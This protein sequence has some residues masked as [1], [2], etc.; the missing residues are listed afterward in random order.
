M[1][2]CE[3]EV[4]GGKT[5]HV[6]LTIDKGLN[7]ESARQL[8]NDASAKVGQQGRAE[9]EGEEDGESGEVEE[10]E[11][12]KEGR[13]KKRKQGQAEGGS[14]GKEKNDEG[15]PEKEG[16]DAK[17]GKEGKKETREA[18]EMRQWR[19]RAARVNGFYVSQREWLGRKHYVLAILCAPSPAQKASVQIFRPRTSAANRPTP[20]VDFL[21]KY[22]KL[23]PSKLSS[24]Q[25][26][27][28]TEYE[29]SATK[30]SRI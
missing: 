16:K 20:L 27:W 23:P 25:A 6:V 9:G 30:V 4:S 11:K 28:D 19:E 15:S 14:G 17:E 24:L 26:I 21:D 13:G 22:S 12:G 3:D 18:K 8:F 7:W 10:G 1:V 2:V 29:E 5:F